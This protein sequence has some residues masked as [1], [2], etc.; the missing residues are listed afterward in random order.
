M[1]SEMNVSSSWSAPRRYGA[2]LNPENKRR[3]SGA[4]LLRTLLSAS[5]AALLG[6]FKAARRRLVNT[7]S[8]N[9]TGMVLLTRPASWPTQLLLLF[10]LLSISYN[11]SEGKWRQINSK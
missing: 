7:F 6:L 3:C 10:L 2:T 5:F 9:D 8:Q 11:F 1:G 4:V